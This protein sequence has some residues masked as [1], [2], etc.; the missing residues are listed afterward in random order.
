MFVDTEIQATED[1]YG[2]CL[3]KINHLGSFYSET[4]R[5]TKVRRTF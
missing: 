4:G 5:Q 1:V 2:I 3:M